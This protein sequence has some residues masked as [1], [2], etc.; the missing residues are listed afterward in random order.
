MA[1]LCVGDR[2]FH[3]QF[4]IGSEQTGAC[5]VMQITPDRSGSIV[6]LRHLAAADG[7]EHT[8][9]CYHPTHRYTEDEGARLILAGVTGGNDMVALFGPDREQYPYLERGQANGRS[10]A[11][12]RSISGKNVEPV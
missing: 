6:E 3:V 5:I 7:R 2:I 12:G 4:P 8:F 11:N 9:T 10:K 1:R